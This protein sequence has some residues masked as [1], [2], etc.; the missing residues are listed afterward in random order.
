[1][2]IDVEEDTMTALKGPMDILKILPKTNCRDC[3]ERTCL[4]FASAVF[5]A[6]RSLDECP[7]L[8]PETLARLADNVATRVPE[9]RDMQVYLEQVRSRIKELDFAATAERVGGSYDGARL[10]LKVM[11]KDF[12][13]YPDGRLSSEIHMN[14]WVVGPLLDY[15][16]SSEGKVPKEIWVQ[17]RDLQGGP[18]RLGLFEQRCVK[19][20]KRAADQYSDLFQ[21]MLEIFS[22]NREYE[23]FGSDISIILRPLPKVPILV[24]YWHP[25]EGMA[26]DMSL[27]FDAT[28]DEN[29]GA[30]SL[31]TIVAGLANMFERI[32]RNHGF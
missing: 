1:M 12:H 31:F 22:G 21:D 6:S 14:P 16:L 29:L 28:A 3:A 8:D 20:L 19:P 2:W 32:A 11:G 13:L 27:F 23:L 18:E 9:G 5:R 7:H 10:I 30:K 4:A 15:V 25:S 17:F 24:C 26:S